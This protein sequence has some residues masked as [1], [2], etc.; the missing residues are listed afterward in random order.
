M[1]SQLR[2]YSH[3]GRCS[4]SRAQDDAPSQTPALYN[5]KPHETGRRNFWLGRVPHNRSLN[6][7]SS[8]YRPILVG[9]EST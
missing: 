8:L 9:S 2:E 7:R 1:I 4:N 5:K 6:M 3:C